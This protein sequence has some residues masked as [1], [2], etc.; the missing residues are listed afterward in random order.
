MWSLPG[1][2]ARFLSLPR[3]MALA[4]RVCVLWVP[5]FLCPLFVAA[6]LSLLG[7]F[8]SI[9]HARCDVGIQG[10]SLELLVAAE[11]K[12]LMDRCP[13]PGLG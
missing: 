2:R 10:N 5:Q 11:L 8:L 4:Q 13:E 7:F 3:V 1:I 9:T 12:R 6:Q